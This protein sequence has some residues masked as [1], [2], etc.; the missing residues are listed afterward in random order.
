MEECNICLT[1]IKKRNKK[2][3]EL[4]K[5]HNRFSNL[6][7][8]ICIEKNDEIV[9]FKD[10]LQSYYDKHKKKFD[11]FTVCVMWMK[12]GLVVNKIS[13]PSKIPYHQIMM[14][15]MITRKRNGV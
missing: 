9:K 14:K 13:V 6:I 10:I 2:K 4:S 3:H 12:N 15:L 11:N 8:N 7:I 5:K 1:K